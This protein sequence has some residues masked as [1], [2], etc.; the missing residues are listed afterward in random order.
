MQNSKVSGID[1]ING[2]DTYLAPAVSR[3]DEEGFSSCSVCPCHRAAAI[4]PPK[5]AG[6]INQ[7]STVHAAF[8]LRLWAR[9]SEYTLEA[10]W[11]VYLRCSSMTRDLPMGD[12]VD[13]LQKFGFPPPCYPSY[14]AP[15]YYP[16]GTIPH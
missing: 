12:F 5:W 14:W 2:R 3:R 8:A 13:R 11:R 6:R 1:G 16:G 9:P 15:D 10:T 7:L 4:T